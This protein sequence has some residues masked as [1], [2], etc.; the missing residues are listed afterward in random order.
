MVGLGWLYGYI[1]CKLNKYQFSTG[2]SFRFWTELDKN[3][4]KSESNKLNSYESELK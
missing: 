2:A 4:H 1:K 3:N